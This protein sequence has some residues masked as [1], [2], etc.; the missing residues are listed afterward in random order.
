MARKSVSSKS[1]LVGPTKSSSA[2]CETP[3]S[4]GRPLTKA[5]NLTTCRSPS[6]EPPWVVNWI[7]ESLIDS[8]PQEV[9]WGNVGRQRALVQPTGRR[10]GQVTD[11][12]TCARP[13]SPCPLPGGERVLRDNV[14]L[15]AAILHVRR[16]RRRRHENHRHR[17]AFLDAALSPEGVGQ[18]VPQFLYHQ[19][20]R[21]DRPRHRRGAGRPRREPRIAHMDAPASTSRCCPSPR[22]ARRA[23]PPTRR[24]RWRRTPTTGST[25]R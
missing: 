10:H 5:T 20:Q 8:H 7:S 14:D 12:T 6:H 16:Q 25:R 19:P 18:R 24:S 2:S 23:S 9:A 4:L 11:G 1:L 15:P 13:P 3:Q 22:R 17:G 21:A